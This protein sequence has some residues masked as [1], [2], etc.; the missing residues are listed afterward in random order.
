M[1]TTNNK[2]FLTGI[3]VGIIVLYL[4][5]WILTPRNQRLRIFTLG[6]GPRNVVNIRIEKSIFM[7]SQHYY[8]APLLP[9]PKKINRRKLS[10]KRY[11]CFFCK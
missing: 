10:Q 2:I 9:Q 6:L 5:M 1:K 3:L 8:Q 11:N 7:L 4:T